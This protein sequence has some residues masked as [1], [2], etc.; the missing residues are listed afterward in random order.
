MKVGDLVKMNRGY[1]TL[2]FIVKIDREHYG[3]R[4]AYKIYKEVPRGKAIRSSMVDG[5]GRTKDGIRDRVLVL[6]PDEG[7]S[8]E[9]SVVLE[10]VSES[11]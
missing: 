5:I 9:E 3:A 8:Y 1:S 4:Q 6:W 10:V 7:Y 11:R 2:G